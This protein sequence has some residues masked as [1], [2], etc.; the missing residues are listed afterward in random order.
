MKTELNCWLRKF[1]FVLVSV[2]SVLSCFRG[3]EPCWSCRE[4]LRKEKGFLLLHAFLLLERPKRLVLCKEIIAIII[5]HNANT[6][7]S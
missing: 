4:V 6:Y 2:M 3:G 7:V 5:Y 1:A